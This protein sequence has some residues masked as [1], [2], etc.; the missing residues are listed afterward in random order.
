MN[1]RRYITSLF[2]SVPLHREMMTGVKGRYNA[3]THQY[4]PP[5]E[6]CNWNR[7]VSRNQL[8]INVKD[9]L[10]VLPEV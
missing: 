10:Y 7:V 5:E 3:R 4:D 8:Q 1:E 2:L 9:N 6:Y